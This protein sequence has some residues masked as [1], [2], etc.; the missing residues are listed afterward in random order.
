MRIT[1]GYW[2]P[3]TD[4]PEMCGPAELARVLVDFRRFAASEGPKGFFLAA[5]LAEEAVEKLLS[6]AFAASHTRDEGRPTRCVLYVPPKEKLNALRPLAMMF[7]DPIPLENETLAKAVSTIR[8][9]AP[10]AAYPD[11]AMLLAC[12]GTRVDIVGILDLQGLW[13][14]H[15]L[16]GSLFPTLRRLVDGMR[17]TV[18]DPGNLIVEEDLG[19]FELRSGRILTAGNVPLPWHRVWGGFAA[20]AQ[21]LLGEDAAA[22]PEVRIVEDVLC[23]FCDRVIGDMVRWGHGGCLVLT[24]AEGVESQMEI[25]PARRVVFPVGR[26]AAEFVTALYDQVRNHGDHGTGATERLFAPLEQAMRLTSGLT[27]VD[28]AVVF[29]PE[30]D[31]RAFGVRLKRDSSRPTLDRCID[32]IT[33]EPD[34][35]IPRL[36]EQTGERHNSAAGLCSN[37]PGTM[38]IVVSQ[39][40]DVRVFLNH[41]GKLALYEPG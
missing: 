21:R 8:A 23:E 17:I 22:S 29:G 13:K 33:G 38:A 9:L 30:F 11:A 37:S 41:L 10:A 6:V 5:S 40:G 7:R 39:D 14:L 4:L 35:D 31:L 25:S 2:T 18:N 1:E 3:P 19:H 20:I 34:A 32:P 15:N 27:R 28:G 12:D 36:L 26:F 16:A 24:Q